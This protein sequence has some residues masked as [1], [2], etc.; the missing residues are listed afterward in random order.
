M[1][2]KET[3]A[4]G[5]PVAGLFFLLLVVTVYA[6]PLFFRRNFAGRDVR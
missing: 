4:R 5:L 6:N 1:E 2:P 3:G